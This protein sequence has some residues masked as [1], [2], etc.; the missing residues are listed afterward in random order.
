MA[1]K[2]FCD[3]CGK[4]LWQPLTSNKELSIRSLH[5]NE[6]L[7]QLVNSEILCADCTIHTYYE[8][9]CEAAKEYEH[10]C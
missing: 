2:I 3:L 10:D 8:P 7:Y 1:I 5:A 4:E 6:T 9:Y